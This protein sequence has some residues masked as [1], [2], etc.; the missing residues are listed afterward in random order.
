MT[1]ARSTVRES[2]LTGFIFF[3]VAG[4]ENWNE[5]EEGRK[6]VVDSEKA[7]NKDAVDGSPNTHQNIHPEDE[8]MK[9]GNESGDESESQKVVKPTRESPD[10]SLLVKSASP[11]TDSENDGTIKLKMGS[12]E[13]RELKGKFRHPSMNSSSAPVDGREHS[14]PSYNPTAER[15]KNPLPMDSSNPLPTTFSHE[16]LIQ[17]GLPY[18]HLLPAAI[19][20]GKLKCDTLVDFCLKSCYN[21]RCCSIFLHATKRISGANRSLSRNGK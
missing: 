5:S 2:Y 21:C 9:S 4:E 7:D 8:A 19:R 3:F 12:S 6:S 18:L 13:S 14:S 1:E 16:Q 10:K 20:N 15:Q 11:E 17:A